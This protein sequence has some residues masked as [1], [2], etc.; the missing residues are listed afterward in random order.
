MK[1]ETKMEINKENALKLWGSRFGKKQKVKDFAGREIMRSAYDDRNSKYGWNID[2]ILPQSQGGKSTES[3]LICCS[4][5]TNDEKQNSFPCFSANDRD[6][7]IK[8]VQN[9]FEIF[10]KNQQNNTDDSVNFFSAAEG[11]DYFNSLMNSNNADLYYS[12]VSINIEVLDNAFINPIYE[13]VNRL[14]LN[15]TDDQAEIVF[16]DC[17]KGGG[18]IKY[19]NMQKI[20]ILNRNSLSDKQTQNM[21]DV[22]ILLKTYLEYFVGKYISDFGILLKTNYVDYEFEN[23]DTISV[24]EDF[25]MS[26]SICQNIFVIDENT[27]NYTDMKK[28]TLKSYTI[29]FDSNYYICDFY[30]KDVVKELNKK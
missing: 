5:L 4:I 24:L 9:H 12:C 29:N 11:M 20:Y 15:S 18:F 16:G 22:C 23:K 6:F 21:L 1:K 17:V 7:E 27:K 30:Y 3:N 25:E 10:E 19:A 8:R 2:H 28:N 13:F 14:F 26:N